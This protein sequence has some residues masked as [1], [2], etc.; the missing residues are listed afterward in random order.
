M[1]ELGTKVREGGDDIEVG[2]KY[3]IDNIEEVTTEVKAFSGVRVMLVDEKKNEGSVMLWRRPV[4]SQESKL[5]AFITLLGSNTDKW[6]GKF[7][8]F[9][10]WRQGARL[11]ELAK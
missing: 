1:P 2:V 9:K 7:I 5:G 3:H 11:V 8:I 6:L 4:T 10:D